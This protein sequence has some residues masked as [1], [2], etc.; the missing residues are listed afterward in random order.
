[1]TLADGDL[2]LELA[3]G[4]GR[5][6]KRVAVLARS[7]GRPLLPGVEWLAAPPDAAGYAHALYS[8]LR[9]LDEAGCD[10]IVVEK[11][12]QAPEWAAI[13]D[14]LARASAGTTAPDDT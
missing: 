7:S 10:A 9:R 2:V 8:N 5:Q 1:L 11:P 3:A 4:L 14:R 6:G 12:P 13:N